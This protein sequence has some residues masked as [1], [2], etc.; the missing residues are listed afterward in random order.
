MTDQQKDVGGGQTA[1]ISTSGRVTSGL[2]VNRA[3]GPITRTV[4]NFL[5]MDNGMTGTVTDQFSTS[6]KSSS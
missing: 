6:V 2:R 4:G 3:T 1:L 5:R